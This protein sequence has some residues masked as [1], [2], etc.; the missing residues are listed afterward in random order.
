MDSSGAASQT[1]SEPSS[2]TRSRLEDGYNRLIEHIKQ[3]RYGI[4]GFYV[5]ALIGIVLFGLAWIPND[6]SVP[7][8]TDTAASIVALNNV[9]TAQFSIETLS[10]GEVALVVEPLTLI[11]PTRG[12]VARNVFFAGDVHICKDTPHYRYLYLNQ[13]AALPI[14]NVASSSYL[15]QSSPWVRHMGNIQSHNGVVGL[16]VSGGSNLRP[17]YIY[18]GGSQRLAAGYALCWGSGG[19][20]ED[21][22]RYFTAIFPHV[23]FWTSLTG[24]AYPKGRYNTEL[25]LHNFASTYNIDAYPTATGA[26]ENVVSWLNPLPAASD[27]GFSGYLLPGGTVQASG[28][29]LNA[30]NDEVRL[31]V[32]GI[33]FGTGGGVVLAIL[34]EVTLPFGRRRSRE[35]DKEPS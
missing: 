18:N 11:D 3:I 4:V 20:F 16:Q 17:E 10:S 32:A 24:P 31:V 33:V 29:E 35:R 27:S 30:Y 7:Q 22:G 9:A 2:S 23:I 26:F 15:A 1:D 8:P 13:T 28:I 25:Y 5:V 12:W 34:Q 21:N 14:E 6:A 19:P